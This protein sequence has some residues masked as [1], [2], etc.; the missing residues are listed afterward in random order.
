MRAKKKKLL[1]LIR[2]DPRLMV[3][4]IIERRFTFVLQHKLERAFCFIGASQ[5]RKRF[6]FL[7]VS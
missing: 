7:S 5:K 6:L 1:R 3:L 2:E 4:V